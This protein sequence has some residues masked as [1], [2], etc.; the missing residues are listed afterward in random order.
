MGHVALLLISPSP[1]AVAAG[2]V[3]SLLMFS[4]LKKPPHPSHRLIVTGLID[5]VWN[6]GVLYLVETEKLPAGQVAMCRMY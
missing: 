6:G 1:P 3:R 5:D 2:Q 4:V